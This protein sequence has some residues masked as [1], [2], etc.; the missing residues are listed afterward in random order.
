MA[1]AARHQGRVG[2]GPHAGPRAS[3]GRA[4]VVARTPRRLSGAHGGPF[5]RVPGRGCPHKPSPFRAAWA[6]RGGG[7]RAGDAAGRSPAGRL[8]RVPGRF[9]LVRVGFGPGPARLSPAAAMLWS[10]HTMAEAWHW[11]GGLGEEGWRGIWEER[12]RVGRRGKGR[13]TRQRGGWGG[14][15]A[16]EKGGGKRAEDGPGPA[17]AAAER[18]E[19]RRGAGGGVGAQ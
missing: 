11:K 5:V 1:V 8:V 19:R 13:G 6:G 9:K 12:A 17:A 4:A 7:A 16:D 14:R 2:H 3:G 10:V 18:G 15:K